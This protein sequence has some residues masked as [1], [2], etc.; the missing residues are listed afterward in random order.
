[1][2]QAVTGDDARSLITAAA[3]DLPLRHDQLYPAASRTGI[4]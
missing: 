4:A 1:M 3:R 2:A